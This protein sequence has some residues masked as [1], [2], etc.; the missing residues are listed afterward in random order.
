MEKIMLRDDL[1]EVHS[2]IVVSRNVLDNSILPE[3]AA[4]AIG[5]LD[6]FINSNT[7][8]NPTPLK[9]MERLQRLHNMSVTLTNFISDLS[10]LIDE[11]VYKEAK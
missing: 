7:R 1:N 11:E 4:K 2:K 3:L 8:Y 6:Y 5:D 10:D 9:E